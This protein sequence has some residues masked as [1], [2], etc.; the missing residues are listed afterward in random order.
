MV[1][2]ICRRAG[3]A[4]AATTASSAANFCSGSCVRAA[5][6]RRWSV[7]RAPVPWAPTPP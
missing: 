5:R 1:K 2:S 3:C 6:P 4:S 7:R